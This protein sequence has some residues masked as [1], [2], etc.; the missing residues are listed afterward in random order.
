MAN[1][2][3][4]SLNKKFNKALSMFAGLNVTNLKKKYLKKI[5]VNMRFIEKVTRI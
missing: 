5:V 3:F 1:K 2:S 4:T